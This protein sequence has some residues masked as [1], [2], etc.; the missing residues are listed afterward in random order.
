MQHW[1]FYFPKISYV[2][3]ILQSWKNSTLIFWHTYTFWSLLNS[4]M[5]FFRCYIYVCMCVCVCVYVIEHDSVK[6][7]HSIEL[8][9][10][11]S[12]TGHRRTNPI[13]FAEYRMNSFF[14]GVQKRILIHPAKN[15]F[16]HLRYFVSKN[17]Y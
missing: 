5:L 3:E 16:E 14:T 13:D 1:N 6:I 7:V 9:F 12:I 10:S 15:V 4:F 17:L 8:K 2:R 11:K